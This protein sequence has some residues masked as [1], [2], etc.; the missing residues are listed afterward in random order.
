MRDGAAAPSRSW[1]FREILAARKQNRHTNWIGDAPESAASR[2]SSGDIVTIGVSP[3]FK[4][5]AGATIFTI[6]SCFARNIEEHLVAVGFDV[7]TARFSLPPEAYTGAVRPNGALNKYN[8][9]SIES[10]I[11]FAL[12][13]SGASDDGL[14]EYGGQWFDPLSTNTR[15]GPL[16]MVRGIRRKI[17]D[18]TSEVRNADAIVIT[19]GLNEVWRDNETGVYLNAMPPHD[20][21]RRAPSRFSIEISDL[22]SN[23]ATLRR[24]IEMIRKHSAKDCRFIVTVSPVPMGATLTGMDVIVANTLSKSMLRVCAQTVCDA[25]DFVD[26]FP[27]YEMVMNSPPAR[28]WSDDRLHVRSD[29]VGVVAKH[30]LDNYVED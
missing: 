18:T 16:D 9:H 28:T 27:S 26:Y 25:Y 13:G 3:K 12:E 24:S 5:P 15:S 4:I 30:F 23:V 22:D 17:A 1:T 11:M 29:V 2:L 20:A 8:T 14:I 7:P 19:L 6:G 10:E 21:I